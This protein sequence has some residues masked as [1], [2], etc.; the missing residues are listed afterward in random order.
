MA[1]HRGEV[2][3]A[4]IA[5]RP[6]DTKRVEALKA[7]LRTIVGRAVTVD[8]TVDESLIGGLV[9]RIGSRMIDGSI[10]TKLARLERAMKGM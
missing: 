8:T 9:V 6:L 10:A 1:V 3:A 5:A 7:K 4:V 2:R